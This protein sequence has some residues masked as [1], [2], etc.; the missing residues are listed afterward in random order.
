MNKNNWHKLFNNKKF[1]YY[2][3][4]K[5]IKI[6]PY[7][8]AKVIFVNLTNKKFKIILNFFEKKLNLKKND[9]FLDFGSGNGAFLLHFQKKVK[10]IYSIEISKPLIKI[11]KKNLGRVSLIYANPYNVK[12]FKKLGDNEIDVTIANSV[13][14]YFHDE[15][16][17]KNVLSEMIRV[18]KRTIFIY[19]IKDSLYKN[20]F[21]SNARKKQNL[22][23]DSFNKKYKYTPQ[24]FYN[25][26]FFKKFLNLKFPNKKIN[27]FNLPKVQE[28][29]KYGYCLKI[30]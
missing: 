30:T 4:S 14:Q 19:D 2:A 16:Y 7:R 26:K 23:I 8:L 20:K 9:N 11:Q 24:R 28:D 29:Y 21:L 12:F 27:F 17:C 1:D 3:E 10:K 22:S 18:T 25:K 5:K 15:N 6:S 13:F